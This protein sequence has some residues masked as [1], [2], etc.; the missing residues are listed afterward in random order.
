MTR[1]RT[2]AAWL[3]IVLTIPAWIGTPAGLGA[4]ARPQL[5]A[6]R[7]ELPARLTDREFWRLVDG[8]TEANG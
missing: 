6:Q 1:R 3:A 4:F 5:A 2:Y 8:F 7:N